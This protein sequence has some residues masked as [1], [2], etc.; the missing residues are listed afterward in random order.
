[1]K[2]CTVE[3]GEYALNRNALSFLSPEDDPVSS[4]QIPAQ[5]GGRLAVASL[6]ADRGRRQSCGISI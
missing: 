2:M 1:M 4:S 6:P 5:S 3:T